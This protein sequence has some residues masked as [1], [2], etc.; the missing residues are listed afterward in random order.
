MK[1]IT[2]FMCVH[3]LNFTT[4]H[5][6]YAHDFEWKYLNVE[7]IVSIEGGHSYKEGTESSAVCEITVA[8]LLTDQWVSRGYVYES[9]D[10]LAKEINRL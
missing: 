7:K 1:I 8:G 10:E 9:C 4:V 6:N 2:L 5:E 3:S